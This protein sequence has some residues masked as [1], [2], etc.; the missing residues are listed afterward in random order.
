MY[1][2]ELDESLVGSYNQQNYRYRDYLYNVYRVA[3]SQAKHFL[4]VYIRTSMKLKVH[5]YIW[6]DWSFLIFFFFIIFFIFLI[7]FFFFKNFHL[8]LLIS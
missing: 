4:T 2:T 3:A 1:M 5:P 7:F 8:Y 6:K